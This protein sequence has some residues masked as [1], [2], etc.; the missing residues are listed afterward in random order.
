MNLKNRGSAGLMSLYVNLQLAQV[1]TY[2]IQNPLNES[3]ISDVHKDTNLNPFSSTFSEAKDYSSASKNSM[4]YNRSKNA[5]SESLST[6]KST[7]RAD[8]ISQRNPNVASL[9]SNQGGDSVHDIWQRLSQFHSDD[10]AIPIHGQKARE[11]PLN[12]AGS[13]D[14][15]LLR[16]QRFQA[17]LQNLSDKL[18]RS[19]LNNTGAQGQ[20]PF[21]DVNR[22][23]SWRE[24]E[25]P[26]RNQLEE[27]QQ[28]LKSKLDEV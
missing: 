11:Q 6:S 18:R 14:S 16:E 26:N 4:A 13:D 28:L 8:S 12:A 25:L 23:R 19:D 10:E 20:T 3:V 24:E 22:Q 15:V 5:P 9:L 7:I 21:A 27:I 1:L 17:G 2:Q